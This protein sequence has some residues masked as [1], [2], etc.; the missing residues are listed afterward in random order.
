VKTNNG[1]TLVF[2]KGRFD[3]WCVHIT[4]PN[5]HKWFPYDY[6]YLHWIRRLSRR[7]GKDKV[8]NDFVK[9]YDVVRFDYDENEAYEIIKEIDTHYYEKTEHWWCIFYMTMVAEEHKEKTIL[10]KRIKRLGVYNVI[11]DGFPVKYTARYMK[12]LSADDLNLIM[13]GKGF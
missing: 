13:R 7:Y 3:D 5:N 4:K 11:F 10:G 2:G 1:Y 8:Y 12:E 9:V 6:E